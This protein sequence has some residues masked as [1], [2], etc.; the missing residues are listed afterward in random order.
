M[1]TEFS[2]TY[3]QASENY[4]SEVY[5]SMKWK[6]RFAVLG[7]ITGWLST[8][9]ALVILVLLVP[10]K[11]FEVITI[12]VDK[13]T[14]FVELAPRLEDTDFSREKR[15]IIATIMRYVRARET[16]NSATIE[17]DYNLAWLMSA[18][19]AADDLEKHHSVTN[20]NRP[21]ALYGDKVIIKVNPNTVTFLNDNTAQARFSTEERNLIDGS[22]ITRFYVAT[23]KFQFS[24][25]NMPVKF[26]YDNP[27]GF[28]VFEYT[29]VLELAPIEKEIE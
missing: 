28:Q 9:V 21:S 10:L 14:G 15:I 29:K 12:T 22:I 5:R 7:A 6:F 23:L 13:N 11:S 18:G 17:T 2:D 8:L 20:K 1:N 24:P 26:I 4:Y 19:S 3:Y 25:D 27:T 16:Y